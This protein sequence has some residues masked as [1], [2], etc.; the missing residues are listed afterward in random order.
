VPEGLTAEVAK[1]LAAGREHTGVRAEILEIL[2]AVALAVVAIATAWSGYQAARWDGE[3]AVDF[4]K[5]SK[6]RFLATQAETLAGQQRLYDTTAFDFWLQQH[7]NGDKKSATLFVKRFRP[8]YRPAFRAWLA[9]HPFTNPHAPAG[10]ILMP[11]Y[12]NA[13]QARAAMY[14]RRASAAFEHGTQA[15]ENGDKYVRNT[16]L[17]A[18]VLFLV[19]VAQRFKVRNVRYSLLGLSFALL[20]VA[21]Y[22]VATYPVA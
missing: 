2:E 10:P 14:D 3:Q 21:V 19:A 16:V 7:A 11:Q 8:E 4:G 17:L 6:Q 5:S 15:R 12:H 13:Q 1:E 18:T 9:T 20:G 22:F